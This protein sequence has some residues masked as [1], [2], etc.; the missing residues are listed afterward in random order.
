MLQTESL[1]D[2][3]YH[4]I[5]GLIVSL[6]LAP[7]AVIDEKELIERLGIGRTP[8]R[9]ALRPLARG[10][11]RGRGAAPPA[12]AGAARGRVPAT[13]HVRD[14]RRRPGARAAVGGAGGA[15]ARGGAPR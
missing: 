10:G 7:G 5:R 3:A 8:G 9:E 4:A 12:C 1:A 6:D 2:K 13:R 14:G 15:R 11:V